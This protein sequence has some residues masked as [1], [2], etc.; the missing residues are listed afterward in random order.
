MTD[1]KYSVENEFEGYPAYAIDELVK[2][3]LY[4]RTREEVVMN[5]ILKGIRDELGRDGLLRRIDEIL[6]KGK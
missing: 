6:E 3:R 2:T 4:G 5:L 1:E